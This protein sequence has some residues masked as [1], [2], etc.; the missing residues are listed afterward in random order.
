MKILLAG[1]TGFIG[2]SLITAL[3]KEGHSII[4]LTRRVPGDRSLDL[5]PKATVLQWDGKS[6][7]DW[8]QKADGVDAIINLS[9][10]GIADKRWT[11][12]R[13]KALA[14]SRLQS[15]RAIVNF[16]KKATR[17]PVTYMNAS[18][19]G[20]YGNVPLGNV[21]ENAPRGTGFLA[22]LCEQWENEAKVAEGL[23]VRT[24]LLRTGIV[25][26]RGGGAIE[27]MLLPF[28]FFVGGPLGSGNQGFPWIHREDEIGAMLFLLQ[29]P[30]ISGPVNLTAPNPVTMKEFCATL[31]KVMHRPSWA[32]VPA[33]MLRFLLG[34][35]A[36]MLLE[37]QKVVPQKLIAAGYSFK[38]PH[39]EEALKAILN[40]KNRL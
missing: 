25:L 1:A 8:A 3:I 27:K 4:V 6:V 36:D 24:V 15:T 16:I 34:E 32:P 13:K 30:K 39:L 5:S 12:E 2:Q 7:G 21:L 31:G 26:E 38:Y 23:G 35:M 19:V 17:K 29:N 10:E 22:E 28:K 40:P 20:Y 37:G 18:A 14:D 9:G 33:F 11:P